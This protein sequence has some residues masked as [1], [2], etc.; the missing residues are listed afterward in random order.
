MHAREPSAESRVPATPGRA[1]RLRPLATRGVSNNALARVL[2]G[3]GPR[4]R[5]IQRIAAHDLYEWQDALGHRADLGGHHD[6][7]PIWQA[8]GPLDLMSAG[9]EQRAPASNLIDALNQALLD[10]D[11][12][13]A[14][15][16]AVTP[17]LPGQNVTNADVALV[18]RYDFDSDTVMFTAENY[19]PWQRMAGGHATVDDVKFFLHELT[20]VR[21]LQGQQLPFDPAG[22]HG[23]DEEAVDEAYR[24]AHLAGLRAE[25][26]LLAAAVNH[27]EGLEQPVTWQQVAL[28]DRT[29]AEEIVAAVLHF[30]AGLEPEEAMDTEQV[31]RLDELRAEYLQGGPDAEA[32]GDAIQAAKD[33]PAATLHQDV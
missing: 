4:A 9:P 6:L 21:H 27:A 24:P 30:D 8:L 15:A 5:V 33:Q 10:R 7:A 13:G 1:G 11:D 20:E 3:A 29:R 31:E 17:A 2:S 18:K 16:A 26:Q 25:A 32:L 14:I 19:V 28:C 12:V 23:A 22:H